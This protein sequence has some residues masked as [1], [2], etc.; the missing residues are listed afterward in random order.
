MPEP[1]APADALRKLVDHWV[2]RQDVMTREL[3]CT[4]VRANG[5]TLSNWVVSVEGSPP[6]GT[7]LLPSMA[8][9]SDYYFISF[10]GDMKKVTSSRQRETVKAFRSRYLSEADQE[11][12][13]PVTASVG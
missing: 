10:Q 13:I 9:Q 3:V 4:P 2:P 12:R 8:G 1:E 5:G 6:R 11:V 7:L